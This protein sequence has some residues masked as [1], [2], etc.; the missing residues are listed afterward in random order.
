MTDFTTASVAFN[1]VSKSFGAKQVLCDVTFEV[2][3]GQALCILGRS[4]TG[5]SVTLKL[6]ISLLKPDS[7][8][9]WIENDE[10]TRLKTPE[11]S[12]VRR[13]MGYLFQDA[14]LFDSLTLYENLALPLVRLTQKSREEIDVG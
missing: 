11:L 7:G 12:R 6:I 8:T 2:P 9:I 5:K 10:I 14:A 4:G 1:H 13:K 3:A